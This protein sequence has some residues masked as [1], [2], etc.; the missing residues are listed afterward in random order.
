MSGCLS[1]WMS[2]WIPGCL[3]GCQDVYLDVYLDAEAQGLGSLS[4]CRDVYLDVY[5]ESEAKTDVLFSDDNKTVDSCSDQLKDSAAQWSLPILS[6][7]CPKPYKSR[8]YQNDRSCSM[9]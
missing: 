2:I 3:S 7:C 1:G 8:Y 4:G 5:L 6:P 9:L